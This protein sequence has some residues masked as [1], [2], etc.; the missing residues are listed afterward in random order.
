MNYTI[1]AKGKKIGRLATEVAA[2]LMGKNTASFRKNIVTDAKVTIIN[3]AQ[4]DVTDKKLNEKRYP[5][6]SGHPGGFV[7]PTMQQVVA[8][9]GFA[10]I[11]RDAIVGMLP[12]NKLQKRMMKNLTI[13]E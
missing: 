4:V 3:A 13:T 10:E 9:K 1:D 2:I 11:F 8:K 5:R 7:E 12:K 6:Y